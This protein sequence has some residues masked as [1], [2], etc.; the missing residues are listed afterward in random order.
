LRTQKQGRAGAFDLNPMPAARTRTPS[1]ARNHTAP[2]AHVLGFSLAEQVMA[3]PRDDFMIGAL[4]RVFHSEA[5][6]FSP[7]DSA[8]SDFNLTRGVTPMNIQYGPSPRFSATGVAPESILALIVVMAISVVQQ[9]AHL[10]HPRRRKHHAQ[11][12]RSVSRCAT[13]P[14]ATP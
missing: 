1:P 11:P 10:R 3:G 4:R 13:S 12:V 9:P 8:E 14:A 5:V 7:P 6:R 2:A